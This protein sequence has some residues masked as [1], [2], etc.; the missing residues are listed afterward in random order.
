[1]KRKKPIFR[2]PVS[3]SWRCSKDGLLPNRMIAMISYHMRLYRLETIIFRRFYGITRNTRSFRKEVRNDR[4]YGITLYHDH[5]YFIVYWWRCNEIVET[6]LYS[7]IHGLFVDKLGQLNAD[8]VL[9]RVNN[10]ST[11]IH[12]LSTST[13]PFIIQRDNES[14]L[15]YCHYWRFPTNILWR[16]I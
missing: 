14:V 2:D 10:S 11:Q 13:S 5:M 6:P 15:K 12:F 9:I 16:R 4:V 8:P 1:M 7:I 3:S